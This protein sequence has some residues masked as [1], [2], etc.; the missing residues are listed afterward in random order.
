MPEL[1]EVETVRRTLEGMIAGCRI[2]EIEI[3]YPKMIECGCEKFVSRLKGRSFQEFARR[4]KYLLFEMEDVILVSHLRMEGK[5]WLKQNGDPV[6]KHTHVIFGLSRGRELRYNDTRKFGTMELCSPDID[7]TDFHGLGPEPFDESFSAEYLFRLTKQRNT[8]LKTL[9]LDQT[10]VAGI[11]NIYADEICFACGLRPRMNC[12][13]LT[14]AMCKDIVR[15][16]RR[17]LSEAVKAGGTTIRSYTSSLGVT[18]LFQL[19]CMVHARKTCR[20]CGSEIKIVR[21][22]GRSSY[23]CPHCQS[24]R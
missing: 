3:R 22:G 13:R 15:E 5:Y 2:E 4:G 16:T 18:G 14:R 23:Y 7:L 12:R 1:P 10:A 24:A 8:P 11:G 21:V 17:I 19:E 9:L 6:D 20:I